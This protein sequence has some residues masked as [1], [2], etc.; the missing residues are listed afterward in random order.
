MAPIDPF[1]NA[2]DLLAVAQPLLTSLQIGGLVTWGLQ[3][4][5]CVQVYN[6][7]LSFPDDPKYMK[8]LVYSCLALELAQ[9]LMV[10]RDTHL[11]FAAGYGDLMALDHLHLLWLTLPIL[12]GIVGLLCH[13]TFAWRISLLSGSKIVGVIIAALAIAG[14]VA[15]FVFGG[16][17]H[18]AQSL[19]NLVLIKHIYLVC[20][21][22]NGLGAA[23]DIVIAG[24]MTYCLSR[25][26]TGFRNT[27]L[28]LTRIMRLTIET[29]VFTATA[30]ICSA[31]L[32][33]GFREKM[34]TSVYFVIPAIM[35]TKLYAITIVATFNNRPDAVGGPPPLS[36]VD[37]S[38]DDN[39]TYSRNFDR[40][41]G[42]IRIGRTVVQQVWQDEVPMSH[43]NIYRGD[44]ANSI[45]DDTASQASG[46]APESLSPNDERA[47]RPLKI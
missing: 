44:E 36:D 46:K 47:T 13:L 28:L 18:S 23:C 24:C 43:L 38:F 34:T 37:N 7:Y 11:V 5:L 6:Y 9:T 10:T 20:G 4:V 33:V 29:G 19:S 30:S 17:M 42:E 21:L 40:I 15:A 39:K 3:G 35:L 41:Q 12:G 14:A 22:W 2:A 31:V 1:I 25:S 16:K 32:F 45:K 27:D 26:Q 8:G